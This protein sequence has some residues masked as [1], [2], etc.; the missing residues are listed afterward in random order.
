MHIPKKGIQR[1]AW[2]CRPF[3]FTF[4]P[5]DAKFVMALCETQ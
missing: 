4:V 1:H 5:T 2:R 3:G